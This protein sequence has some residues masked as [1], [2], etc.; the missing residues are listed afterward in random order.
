MTSNEKNL[1]IYRRSPWPMVLL[2][3]ALMS[4]F[5]AVE[6]IFWINGWFGEGH[7]FLII[8]SA[9]RLVF[10]VIALVILKW[11][12]KGRFRD[13]FLRKISKKTVFLLLPVWIF[14]LVEGLM[15][16]ATEKVT[17]VMFFPFLLVCLQQL[18]TGLYEEGAG[19]GIVMSGF[20]SKFRSKVSGRLLMV[21]LAGGIFGVNHVFNF[22]FGSTLEECLWQGL[23]TFVWGSFIAAIYLLS[24]NLGL[25]MLL[26]AVWDIIIRIPG[27]F[28]ILSKTSTVPSHISTIQDVLYVIFLIVAIG[29]C[30][31]YDRLKTNPE[32]Q[33]S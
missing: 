3:T 21:L 22:L 17:F 27:A 13:L 23:Y 15:I 5:M 10:G 33:H 6:W 25:V 4:A 24:E 19:R 14:F 9:I 8:D 7:R 28:M 12:Y 29:I 31:F 11:F 30:I 1:P 32:G 18:T 2:G 16:F 20:S 26:H